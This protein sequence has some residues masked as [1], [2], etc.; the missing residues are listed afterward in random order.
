LLHYPNLKKPFKLIKNSF[1]WS[2]FGDGTVKTVPY[3]SMNYFKKGAL[4]WVNTGV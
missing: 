2:K 1:G 3:T 4:K